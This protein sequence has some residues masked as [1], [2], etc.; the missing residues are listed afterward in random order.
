M[1]KLV[2]TLSKILVNFPF[3]ERIFEK[4]LYFCKFWIKF[5]KTSDNINP[6]L[7]KNVPE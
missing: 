1:N 5:V 7:C 6:S 2:V 3:F 4:F